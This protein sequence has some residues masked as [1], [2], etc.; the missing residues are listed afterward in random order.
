[1]GL[2]LI[3]IAAVASLQAQDEVDQKSYDGTSIEAYQDIIGV[4]VSPISRKTPG[5]EIKKI[6]EGT[7]SIRFGLKEI[8][9]IDEINGTMDTYVIEKVDKDENLLTVSVN[10]VKWNLAFIFDL[11]LNK[12]KQLV[13]VEI[14]GRMMGIFY[15]LPD[16]DL[17]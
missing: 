5:D 10:H 4:T 3:C 7:V 15:G 17:D 12:K 13:S 2:F 8:S 6:Q 11:T 9:V 16:Y 1:M 14:S